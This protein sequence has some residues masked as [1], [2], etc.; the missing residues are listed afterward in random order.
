MTTTP[1][2]IPPW[3]ARESEE[4][5]GGRTAR[6]MCRKG[7]GPKRR[8]RLRRRSRRCSRRRSLAYGVKE[9]SDLQPGRV[10]AVRRRR[11]S[12]TLRKLSGVLFIGPVAFGPYTAMT[13]CCA[14]C[15]RTCKRRNVNPGIKNSWKWL[16]IYTC[17]KGLCL[18]WISKTLYTQFP[19]AT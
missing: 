5:G 7:T 10:L 12:G 2:L 6:T 15:L 18:I 14:S 16:F 13:G 9:Q 8:A 17:V 19:L 11:S 1:A 3:W 4:S